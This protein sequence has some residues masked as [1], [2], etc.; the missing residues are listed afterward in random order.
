MCLGQQDAIHISGRVSGLTARCPAVC[1]KFLSKQVTSPVD[2]GRPVLC[3]V[4]VS[5]SEPGLRNDG[6]VGHTGFFHARYILVSHLRKDSAHTLFTGLVI[7][8]LGC[9]TRAALQS[10]LTD[11]VSRQQ[12]AVLYTVIALTDG[13]GSA[14]SALVLNRAFALAIGWEDDIY[15]GLPFVIAAICFLIALGGSLFVGRSAV[16]LKH[17]G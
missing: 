17:G 15:M 5:H 6:A 1:Q 7:Y 14:T 8:S 10:L 3:P 13:I 2:E 11:L 12:I 4:W 9:S 16:Q